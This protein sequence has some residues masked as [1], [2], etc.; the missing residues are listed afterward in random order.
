MKIER[1]LVHEGRCLYTLEDDDVWTFFN[2]R[3]V[4][5]NKNK[6]PFTVDKNGH[7]EEITFVP[8]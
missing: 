3:L 6:P 8:Q 7:I 5:A 1:R 4:I 2:D